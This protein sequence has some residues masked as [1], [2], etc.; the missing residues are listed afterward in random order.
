MI[1]LQN[2]DR[3]PIVRSF[4]VELTTTLDDLV[5]SVLDEHGPLSSVGLQGT[6]TFVF[7]D[8]VDSTGLA[9]T[10]GDTAWAEG[11]IGTSPPSVR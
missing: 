6:M 11:E 8:I 3:S 1:L 10:L 7:T 2:S 5:S 4:G 9:E